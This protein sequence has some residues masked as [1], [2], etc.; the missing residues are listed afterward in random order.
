MNCKYCHTYIPED[1]F[2]NLVSF[3]LSPSLVHVELPE[4]ARQ[5]STRLRWWQPTHSGEAQD[6]WALDEIYVG[7]HNALIKAQDDFDVSVQSRGP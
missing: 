1:L 4:V 3:M 5:P 6:Q 7:P 2:D